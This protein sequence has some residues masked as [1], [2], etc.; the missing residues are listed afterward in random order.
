MEQPG[1]DWDAGKDAANYKKH[2]VSFFEAQ[3]AFFDSARVIA[4]DQDHSQKEKLF[5]LR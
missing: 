3:D 1:F 4:K 5:L 2:G